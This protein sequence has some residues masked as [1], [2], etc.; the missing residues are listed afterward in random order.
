KLLLVAGDGSERLCAQAPESLQATFHFWCL[1]SYIPA[2]M[3]IEGELFSTVY[4]LWIVR[5]LIKEIGPAI[6]FDHFLY[7]GPGALN[8]LQRSFPKGHSSFSPLAPWPADKSG[9]L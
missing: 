5:H 2:K 8:G 3:L 9:N 4:E 1:R 6:S 7:T